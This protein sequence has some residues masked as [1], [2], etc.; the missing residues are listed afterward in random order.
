MEV[1]HSDF[2]QVL[3]PCQVDL[4]AS[5]LSA[6][7]PR[8]M[9][10]KPDPGSIATDAVSDMAV[11]RQVPVLDSEGEGQEACTHCP[12]VANPAMACS[13][14]LNAVQKTTPPTEAA[15]SFDKSQQ[16]DTFVDSSVESKAAWLI[17]GVPSVTKEFQAE[18]RPSSCFH[19]GNLLK[20]YIPVA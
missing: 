15:I 9:T 3:G 6:Q 10:W 13:P 19:G 2:Q 8:Y 11:N 18:Q 4:F 20:E 12:S 5:R 17:L 7:L 14:P 16:Q 1:R